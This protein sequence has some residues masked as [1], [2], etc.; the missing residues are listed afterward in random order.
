[1]EVYAAFLA[2]T[3]YEIGRMLAAIRA[4][5]HTEDTAVIYIAGD[6][7]ASAEGGTDGRD[8]VTPEGKPK[9]LAERW[10]QY[11]ALGSESFA[12]MYATAWAWATNSPFQWAKRVASHLGGTRDAMVV[13][14]PGHV[15]SGGGLRSQFLH[16]TDIAPTIYELAGVQAPT[17]VNG[18]KQTPLEGTS[19]VYT[20]DHPD[21]PSRHKV[22]YFEMLGS[23]GIYKDGWWA[24]SFNHLPWNGPDAPSLPPDQRPWELYNLEQDYSQAHNLAA[25]NP[26]KLEELKKLFDAEA[27]RNQVYPLEPARTPQPSLTTGR[28]HFVYH[29]G[30]RRIPPA[31][32]PR[33]GGRAHRITADIVVPAAGAEGVIVAQGG[34][35]GGFTLYIKDGRVTYETGAFGYSR[36]SL[37]SS[38]PLSAGKA[39]VVVEVTP[40]GRVQQDGMANPAQRPPV[41]VVAKLTV[42]GKPAGEARFAA[43]AGAGDTLDIGGDLVSPV[44]AKYASPFAFTGQIES[45][46][47]DLR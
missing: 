34:R 37:V 22:Q 39:S 8:A 2:Q 15:K 23:R 3:D 9:T 42:N 41:P 33:M 14:W 18:V 20:F 4:N 38:E 17:M 30:D 44:S 28:N 21:E 35:Q 6:N 11:D 13:S 10:N 12:N 5:G 19:L 25:K 16:I 7:G 46:T 43:F 45:V 47:I 32:A 31:A 24:G 27:R 36:G 40:A 1:M 29:A 26:Q